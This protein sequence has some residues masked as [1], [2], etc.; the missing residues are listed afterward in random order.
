MG[1][2]LHGQCKQPT[3]LVSSERHHLA[4]HTDSSLKYPS[5]VI[6]TGLPLHTSSEI[7]PTGH[8]VSPQ[9]CLTDTVYAGDTFVPI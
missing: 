4:L 1:T 9:A 2:N 3:N 6:N 5:T 8:D 7:P